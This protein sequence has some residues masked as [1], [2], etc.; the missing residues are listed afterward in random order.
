MQAR[1]WTT[2]RGY[3]KL[4]RKKTTKH[5]IQKDSKLDSMVFVGKT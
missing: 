5:R 1:N 3:F 4:S 2:C